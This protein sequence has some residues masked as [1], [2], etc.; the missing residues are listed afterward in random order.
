MFAG[1]FALWGQYF[2]N[3]LDG[4]GISLEITI[5]GL[6]FALVAGAGFAALRLARFRVLRF[7]GTAYVEVV[8]ATPMLLVLYIM[9]FGLGQVGI[10]L[11]AYWAAVIALGTFY[12]AQFT[13]IFRGGIQSVDR[14]QRE[15]ADALGLSRWQRL[16][17]V[18]L[19]QAVMTI[20]LPSTN[21]LADIIKDSSLVITIGL[22]D[23]MARTYE[24]TSAT[25]E[26]MDMFLLAGVMYLVVYL[27]LSRVLGRL[28][29][30][31][32]RR[33]G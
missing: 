21:A 10:K 31:V 27:L 4:L 28:E 22:S 12:A 29:L 19:P 20:L 6:A 11:P 33:H 13:E 5:A 26:P 14:G 32:Q 15:A 16:R 7:I 1:I 24:A 23:L 18:V 2:G 25:F 17:K 8:R 3:F 9:Y 30:N